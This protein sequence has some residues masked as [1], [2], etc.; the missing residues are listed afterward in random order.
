[1]GYATIEWAQDSSVYAGPCECSDVYSFVKVLKFAFDV[2]CILIYAYL[3]DD[4]LHKCIYHYLIFFCLAF[5]IPMCA[6]VYMCLLVTCWERS[7]L[8]AFVC[9]V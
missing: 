9:G 4:L 5:A 8:L 1:M 7:G 3:Y 6:S 2:A